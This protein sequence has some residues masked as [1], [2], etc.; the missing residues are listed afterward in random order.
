[1][2]ANGKNG[3][4]DLHRDVGVYPLPDFLRELKSER[5][6]R[7]FLERLG[8]MRFK[9]G[10]RRTFKNEYRK[11]HGI[12]PRDMKSQIAQSVKEIQSR[13]EAY[14]DG[15]I[16]VFY[17][18]RAT[19]YFKTVPFPLG[20]IS[21][22]RRDDI[23]GNYRKVTSGGTFEDHESDGLMFG[24]CEIT[25]DQWAQRDIM[26]GVAR[27]LIK[28]ELELAEKEGVPIVA[29]KSRP[30]GIVRYMRDKE[31]RNWEEI[32]HIGRDPDSYNEYMD[33]YMKPFYNE[34]GK[35]VLNDDILGM[36]EGYGAHWWFP[37]QLSRPDDIWSLGSNVM[38]IYRGNHLLKNM[39]LRY[40][41][42]K[43]S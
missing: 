4:S 11:Y 39:R 2:G 19:G 6:S 21:A 29:A 3:T 14:G 5:E 38:M 34:K 20:L 15:E 33:K 16:L 35:L 8:E 1:M 42:A 41:R 22:I 28:E 13:L 9:G 7:G 37:E 40:S 17:K 23:F 18:G 32:K 24:C 30:G 12:N 25:V 10:W 27:G 31:G 36:H 26:K 43:I